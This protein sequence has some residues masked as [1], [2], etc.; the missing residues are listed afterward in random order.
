MGQEILDDVKGLNQNLREPKAILIEY[1]MMLFNLLLIVKLSVMYY[2]YTQETN[3]GSVFLFLIVGVQVLMGGYMI[4]TIYR[5]QQ[6]FNDFEDNKNTL[7]LWRVEDV[8]DN[9]CFTNSIISIW[10]ITFLAYLAILVF[11]YENVLSVNFVINL[12][13]YLGVGPAQVWFFYMV[14]QNYFMIKTELKRIKA[15]ETN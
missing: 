14:D 2:L 1:M 8:H 7:G 15:E 10:I 3:D 12:L 4:M 5:W 6:V 13:L 9:G 11:N